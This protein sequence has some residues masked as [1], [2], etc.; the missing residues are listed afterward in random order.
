ML[1]AVDRVAAHREKRQR[2][3]QLGP[4][5]FELQRRLE[6]AV[7]V[8]TAP[9]LKIGTSVEL[10][11]GPYYVSPTGSPR[12]QYDVTADGQRALMLAPSPDTNN[13]RPR[14]RVVVVQNWFADVKRLLPIE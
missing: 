11:Q 5:P 7:P 12:A 3:C 10:F 4:E 14:P 8:A 2:A 1:E 13:S 9:T 6:I